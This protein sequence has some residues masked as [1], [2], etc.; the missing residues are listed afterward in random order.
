[1]LQLK[2]LNNKVTHNFTKINFW[3]LVFPF[4]I[5]L[6]IFLYFTFVLEGDFIKNYSAVQKD[7]FYFLNHKLSQFPSFQFNIT[8]LGDALIAFSFLSLLFAYAPKFWQALLASSL[9]SLIVSAV[10]KRIFAMPRPAAVFNTD[11]FTIIGKKLTGATSLPSGHSM[12]IFMV[13]T[14]LL[15]AFMPSKNTYKALWTLLILSLGLLFALSRVGVGAHYPLD[16]IIGCLIG[17]S[18]A[19]LGIIINE[20]KNWLNWIGN[21]KLYPV[22]ILLFIIFIVSLTK[23]IFE[24][25]LVVFYLSIITLLITLYLMITTYVK[26]KN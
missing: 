7:L 6:A 16:V 2:E 23:K 14:L 24:D 18:V 20:K 1:M 10:L 8:Q 5:L 15:Y 11:E 19:V 17:Y 4:L 22:F 26:R 13:I 3:F 25:N 9:L 12:T 21:L